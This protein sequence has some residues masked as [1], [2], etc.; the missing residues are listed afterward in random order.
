M[1]GMYGARPAP[2]YSAMAAF[3]C[4]RSSRWY[5]KL[6]HKA[7]FPA[8]FPSKHNSDHFLDN[9]SGTSSPDLILLGGMEHHLKI[10]G[11]LHWQNISPAVALLAL[12]RA[13]PCSL[14]VSLIPQPCT[15]NSCHTSLY[16]TSFLFYS[17]FFLSFSPSTL[18][19]HSS[20]ISL[21]PHDP[22]PNSLQPQLS[23]L[24]Y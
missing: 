21:W 22:S 13:T 10:R 23:A 1:W 11:L 2:Q 3:L 20:F 9:T 24:L 16:F 8:L 14:F 17:F 19:L 7:I 15:D 12:T 6:S 18:L 5:P 4:S